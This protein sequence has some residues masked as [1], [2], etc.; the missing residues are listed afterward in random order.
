[1]SKRA[2]EAAWQLYPDYPTMDGGYV[3]QRKQRKLVMQGYEQA[4]KDLALTWRDIEKIVDIHRD[5]L[6][7]NA[8]RIMGA[9]ENYEDTLR[10]FNEWKEEQK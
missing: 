5:V 7:D 2:E 4:E 3:S 6:F 1:M 8:K 10:K 9:K